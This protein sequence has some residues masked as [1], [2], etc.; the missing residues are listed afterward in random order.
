MDLRGHGES[1]LPE[2]PADYAINKLCQDILAVADACE[3]ERF[4]L[5]GMSYGGKVG[6]GA[7]LLDGLGQF[8]TVAVRWVVLLGGCT[9]LID[10]PFFAL[11]FVVQKVLERIKG[12]R[13]EYR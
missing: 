5:W 13:L 4:S 12:V 2:D 1:D 7:L 3:V 9:L 10:L 8:L 11:I 6:R